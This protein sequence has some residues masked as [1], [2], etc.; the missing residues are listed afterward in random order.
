M[1]FDAEIFNKRLFLSPTTYYA[2]DNQLGKH[3]DHFSK[4]FLS[5]FLVTICILYTSY[6]Q[7]MSIASAFISGIAIC[8]CWGFLKHFQYSMDKWIKKQ[9]AMEYHMDEDLCIHSPEIAHWLYVY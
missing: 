5:F 3:S 9:I 4:L 2:T 8:K 1:N 6:M 7:M